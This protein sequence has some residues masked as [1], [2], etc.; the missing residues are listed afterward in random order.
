MKLQET[1]LSLVPIEGRPSYA[2]SNAPHNAAAKLPA[3]PVLKLLL[4]APLA[5]VRELGQL[6]GSGD[7]PFKP[8]DAANSPVTQLARTTE[9]LVPMIDSFRRPKDG[10]AHWWQRFTGQALER[11]LTFWH[12]CTQLEATAQRGQH[13]L[14]QLR[15]F[16]DSMERERQQA[17]A[18]AAW[19]AQ[20][21]AVGQQA[22]QPRFE[23]Y[24]QSPAFADQPDYWPRFARRLDNLNALHS[25]A[26]LSAEQIKLAQSQANAVQDRFSEVLT[27]L[28]PL[29]RQR[30]GFE[31]FSKQL[32]SFSLKE[33]SL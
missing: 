32:A 13:L 3:L 2:P 1:E 10:A 28:L 19:L 5:D 8:K 22:L 9:Q 31:L 33:S 18:E 27:V 29:W 21:T 6:P 7:T 15:N 16:A 4:S 12:A 17:L 24:R 11:E 26:L 14:P 30:A 25:S 23:V 20:V